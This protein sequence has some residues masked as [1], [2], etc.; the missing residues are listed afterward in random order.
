MTQAMIILFQT[1]MFDWARLN[2][3]QENYERKSVRERHKMILLTC[4]S[5][6]GGPIT[7]DSESR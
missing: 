4:I 2:E 5:E 7:F 3:K 1:D 6:A